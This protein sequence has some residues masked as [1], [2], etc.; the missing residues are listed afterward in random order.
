MIMDEYIIPF[1]AGVL[2]LLLVVWG[3]AMLAPFFGV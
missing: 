1:I 3:I 2:I